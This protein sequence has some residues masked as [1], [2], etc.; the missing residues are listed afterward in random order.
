MLLLIPSPLQMHRHLLR[1]RLPVAMVSVS[2][3]SVVEVVRPA[4]LTVRLSKVAEKRRPQKPLEV[5]ELDA[6]P[7]GLLD[8]ADVGPLV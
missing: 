1:L 8:V 7:R 3:S 5:R 2:I 6:E 4:I